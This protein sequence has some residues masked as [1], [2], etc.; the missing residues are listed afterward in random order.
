M[1][2]SLYDRTFPTIFF[3]YPKYCNEDRKNEREIESNEKIIPKFKIM[4]GAHRY[5]CVVNSLKNAGFEQTESKNWNVLWSA[6]LHVETIKKFN[7]YQRCN[8][9]PSTW[10]IGRKDNLW[11]N[12]ARFFL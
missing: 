2:K 11:R 7:K 6:P 1:L 3:P 9:F 4:E 5:N 8:H 12:F 10:Q